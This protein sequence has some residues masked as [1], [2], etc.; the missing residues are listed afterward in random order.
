[1]HSMYQSMQRLD[2]LLESENQAL[3]NIGQTPNQNDIINEL[4]RLE[5]IATSIAPRSNAPTDTE[6]DVPVT[7]HLLI[8]QHMDDFISEIAQARFRAEA[9]PP[10]YFKVGQLV[11]GCNACHRMR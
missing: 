5:I 6:R 8:D 11:G 3:D 9:N 4:Q 1:M 7:N 2:S 10:R